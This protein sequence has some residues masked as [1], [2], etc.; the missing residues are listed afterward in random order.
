ME[1]QYLTKGSSSFWFYPHLSIPSSALNVDFFLNLSIPKIFQNFRNGLSPYVFHSPSP[2]SRA[3]SFSFS[4][5]SP[6]PPVL[7]SD[8]YT[9]VICLIS[10][11]GTY[12]YFL[13]LSRFLTIERLKIDI[14]EMQSCR[15]H[16]S[17]RFLVSVRQPG[18]IR[19]ILCPELHE[20]THTKTLYLYVR[21]ICHSHY[22]CIKHM[23]KSDVQLDEKQQ[24]I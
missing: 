5:L 13:L 18:L 23:L 22:S 24:Y 16:D 3:S 2:S 4:S 14:F 21:Q 12:F 8:H 17:V 1:R 11:I 10:S 19:H 7:R 6:F 15:T 20:N 9:F